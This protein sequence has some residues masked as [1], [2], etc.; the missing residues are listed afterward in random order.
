[1]QAA[2]ADGLATEEALQERASALVAANVEQLLQVCAISHLRLPGWSL[3][4]SDVTDFS[5]G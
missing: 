4:W 3:D 5:A 1:M 2:L